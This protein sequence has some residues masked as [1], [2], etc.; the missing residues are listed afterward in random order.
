VVCLKY[1]N[2]ASIKPSKQTTLILETMSKNSDDER[3]R[4]DQIQHTFDDLLSEMSD[5]KKMQAQ[6]KTQ[7]DL[8]GAAMDQY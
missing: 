4:W 7:M 3:S 6:M 8:R 2:T 5:T 1:L